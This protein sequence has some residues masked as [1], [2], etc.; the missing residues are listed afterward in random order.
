[1]KFYVPL[2]T[3]PDAASSNAF[4]NRQTMLQQH[5]YTMGYYIYTI[6]GNNVTVDYYTS[7]PMVNWTEHHNTAYS[8][9]ADIY[10]VTPMT[11]T[12]AETWGYNLTGKQF[13]VQ[14]NG[15]YNVVQ[16][17]SA[18]ILGG[19]NTYNKKD[20]EPGRAGNGTTVVNQRQMAHLVTTGW[21]PKTSGLLSDIFTIWGMANELKEVKTDT[22]CLSM[23]YDPSQVSDEL[24]KTGKVGIATRGASTWENAVSQNVG[25]TAKFVEG[26]YNSATHSLGSWGVDVATKTFW[27]VINYNADFAIAPSI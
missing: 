6:D 9:I 2:A 23:S 27:A 16:D 26:A 13:L 21:A 24:A 4:P 22:Y 5:L 1:M 20:G 3:P 17:G 15:S 19:T 12:K 11:F 7:Q 25:G 18:K 14:M 8:D 10:S